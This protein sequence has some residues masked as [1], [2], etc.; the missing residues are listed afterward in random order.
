[1]RQYD[2]RPS[3]GGSGLRLPRLGRPHALFLLVFFYALTVGLVIQLLVLPVL[4]PGLHGGH[5]LLRGTDSVGYYGFAAD[6]AD[7]IRAKGWGLWE[8]RPEN[9][10]PVGIIAAVFAA[11][12][13]YEPWILLPVY[14][15]LFALSAT[16]IFRIVNLTTNSVPAALAAI[17][18]FIIFPSAALIYSGVH[19]DVWTIAGS[20]MVFSILAQLEWADDIR[21]PDMLRDVLIV[22]IGALLVWI[23]RPYFVKVLYLVSLLILIMRVSAELILNHGKPATFGKKKIV[24]FLILLAVLALVSKIPGTSSVFD[25]PSVRIISDVWIIFEWQSL[26]ILEGWG[27]WNWGWWNPLSVI[28]DAVKTMAASRLGFYTSYPGAGS[29][30]DSDVVLKSMLDVVLYIP[31][32]LQIGLFAPF[33]SMWFTTGVNPGSGAMRAISGV[34]MAICYVLLL[35]LLPLIALLSARQRGVALVV[36][37][38][39]TLTLVIMGMGIPNVGTLYRMRYGFLMMLVG[40]GTAGWVIAITRLR[41]WRLTA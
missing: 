7:Q 1:M 32:A 37:G 39:L 17:V 10:A 9:H 3:G 19:K 5:G 33:P 4:L 23:M 29:F 12:G 26:A 25:A 31:R 20:L 22:F 36:I 6:L 30:V 38:L 41:A 40:L 28:D 21:W 35:G 18:P 11:T 13:I 27:W 2:T 24:L 8:L 16:T 15:A 14:A 34:E